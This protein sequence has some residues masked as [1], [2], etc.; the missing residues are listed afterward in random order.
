MIDAVLDLQL[1]DADLLVHV[2]DASGP[3]P[4]LQM[5]SVREVLDEIDAGDVPELLCFNKRDLTLEAK[6]LVDRH[7]GSVAV[8]GITGEGIDELLGAIGD[9]LRAMTDTVALLVPFARGDVLAEIHREGAVVSEEPG[10][11]GMRVTARLDDVGRA[12]LAEFVVGGPAPG[13][14]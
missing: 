4:A 8:S 2:V 6:R 10:D 5:A 9:R 7:P 1:V 14:H 12:R 13:R 11:D 3:D